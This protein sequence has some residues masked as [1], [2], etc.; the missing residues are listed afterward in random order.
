[1]FAWLLIFNWCMV[2]KKWDGE[3]CSFIYLSYLYLFPCS[4]CW[5]P[6]TRTSY[7]IPIRFLV[8]SHLPFKQF[9]QTHLSFPFV[10]FVSLAPSLFLSLFFSCSYL[11]F[12]SS[13]HSFPLILATLPSR[14]FYVLELC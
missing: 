5:F 3:I 14:M 10:P 4:L 13:R 6:T 9:R 1:M 7:L 11:T 2:C 8:C 12:P